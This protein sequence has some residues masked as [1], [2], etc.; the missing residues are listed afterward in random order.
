M[1]PCA[2]W[3]SPHRRA[4]TSCV[5]FLCATMHRSVAHVQSARTATVPLCVGERKFTSLPQNSL[6]YLSTRASSYAPLTTYSRWLSSLT[7]PFGSTMCTPS[8]YGMVNR[9]HGK[10]PFVYLH[11]R[12]FTCT[13]S[14]SIAPNVNSTCRLLCRCCSRREYFPLS[15]YRHGNDELFLK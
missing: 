9:C 13:R 10:A 11:G 12:L 2:S 1:L 15:T 7:D 8:S 4:Q 5:R 6:F 14:S 3:R